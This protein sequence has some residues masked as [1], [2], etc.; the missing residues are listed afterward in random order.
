DHRSGGVERG[1][2]GVSEGGQCLE[3]V[4]T[5]DVGGGIDG[6]QRASGRIRAVS[7]LD[8]G[9]PRRRRAGSDAGV[10]AT[11][12]AARSDRGGSGHGAAALAVADDDIFE[13]RRGIEGA[14]NGGGA[15]RVVRAEDGETGVEG[16]VENRAA[17]T[18]IVARA[19]GVIGG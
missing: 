9:I 18:I 4:G 1:T 17:G 19:I 5:G 12:S 14:G 15:S 7:D 8:V 11:L 13:R 3:D 2:G 6:R 10:I 16:G